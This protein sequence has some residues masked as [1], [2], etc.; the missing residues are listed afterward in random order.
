MKTDLNLKDR[1]EE[2]G[3]IL[4]CIL[5][6][7][8]PILAFSGCVPAANAATDLRAG[9]VLVAEGV[10]EADETCAEV[11]DATK[12]V[13]LA[14]ACADAYDLAR[15]LLESAEMALDASRTD[16]AACKLAGAV[17]AL[18]GFQVALSNAGVSL[19]PLVRDALIFGAGLSGL[20]RA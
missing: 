2:I 6:I 18:Q 8:V 15:P 7:S 16:D 4:L 17:K 19:P 14:G 12:D 11:A 5:L 10:K 3:V 20:C 1:L 9:V 13:M